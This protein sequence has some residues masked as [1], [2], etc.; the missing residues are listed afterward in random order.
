MPSRVLSTLKPFMQILPEVPKPT[1]PVT[2]REK[3]LWTGLV[4]T[5][6]FIMCEV[7]LYPLSPQQPGFERFFFLRLIFAS[8]RGTLAELGIGPIVTAGLIFQ[9][10]VGSRIL[11]LDL[12]D[13]EDR[14]L[15]TGGQKLFAFLFALLESSVY[16]FS[17]IYGL[18]SISAKFAIFMQLFAASILI[19]LMDEMIQKGWG[20]GSGVSLF[21]AAGVAQQIFWLCFAPY[22]M[23]DGYPL[24]ALLAFFSAIA[25][26]VRT[27]SIE[28]LKNVI[29]RPHGLPDVVGFLSMI[30]IFLLISYLEGVRVELPV[31]YSRYRGLRAKIPFKF[32][33]V[34]N[35]PVILT[36]ALSANIMMFAQILWS[37]Y[38]NTS[39][40]K[41]IKWFVYYENVNGTNVL[42]P[43]LV[44]YLSPP[45]N[46]SDVAADPM[47]ALIYLLLFTMLCVF[48]AIA[49]VETSGMDPET[50]AE[51]IVRAGLQIPGF[52]RSERIVAAILRRYIP[53]LTILSG[54]AVGLIAAVADML[55]AIG[56]GMGILLLIDILLQ[57]QAIM[58]QER[59][60][61]MY[62]L[63]RRII[64]E[65]RRR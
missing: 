32:L 40:I 17:G 62:P 7:T 38:S 16:A 26:S 63:L 24:G 43:S 1:R 10:L 41:Y 27:H 49:W 20:L 47:R 21:I 2:F 14:A 42:R 30:G 54:L 55:G 39:A 12:S 23:D 34:S 3:L 60:L 44:Y 51:Q 31:V 53:S 11:D 8:R 5:I 48:F 15:F 13:P 25:A 9:L 61:E 64:G 22:P 35:V 50:Q 37:R 29:V 33:Y 58:M 56:T 46:L 28:P 45:G 4:L 19:I 57:Y 52:R 65:R 6:Y 36:G 59:A 18:T